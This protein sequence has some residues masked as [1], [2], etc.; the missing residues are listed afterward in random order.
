MQISKKFLPSLP[1]KTTRSNEN[2]AAT[3]KS[4]I[5]VIKMKES[6]EALNEMNPDPQLALAQLLLGKVAEET[7]LWVSVLSLDNRGVVIIIFLINCS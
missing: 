1:G 7:C 6:Y 4:V 5:D 2:E 3:I